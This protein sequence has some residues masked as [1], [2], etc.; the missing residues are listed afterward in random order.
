VIR[1]LFCVIAFALLLPASS[2]AQETTPEPAPQQSG[3]TIHVV[4]RGET[5]FRI[6][7]RYG[8][9]VDEL[10]RLNGISDPGSI[11]VGQRLLVPSTG[12]PEPVEAVT[13]I[14]QP[15]ETLRSI[16]ESYGTTVETLVALNNIA[17][18]NTIY[19]GQVLTITPA[20][21]AAAPTS[22]PVSVEAAP[23]TAMVYVVQ[24]GETLFRIA[25]RF[26]LTVNDL[27]T[28]NSIS[29]P[30]V[31]YVGQQLI[32]P[33]FEPP[34]LALDLPEPVTALDVR[35]L[36][37]VEGQAAWIRLTT[38]E[39]VTMGGTFFQ[40]VLNIISEQNNTQ[41]NILIGVPLGTAAGVYA[42]DLTVTH[43]AGIQIP[44]TINLQI[45]SG[46]YGVEN[47]TLLADR[48]NLL[49][50]A[51]EQ[52]E[53]DI[54]TSVMSIYTL[55]RYFDGPMG[56]PAAAA[57][58][59][60][61]GA[62]RSYNGGET[63]RRHTGTDFAGAPG[64]PVLAAASGVV[65]LADTLNVRGNAVVIDHGWGVFTGYWH[66]AEL[67]VAVG[68]TV[69]TGQVIGTIG[70]TGRVTGAHLHWEVWVSGVPVDPMQW[71]QQSFP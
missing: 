57:V 39:A 36:I 18:A 71:I 28:A 5:L 2:Y 44:L 12:V 33:G 25:T 20:A 15:G 7:L 67:F 51:V 23:V 45:L 19:V 40:R 3:V 69:T 55:E 10:V 61:F 42:L 16:A 26:G 6:A 41:H 24:P 37:L 29:D 52:A 31:I 59:S 43:S 49:E 48:G 53:L 17:N 63:S 22:E 35:P 60:A 54:I 27:V 11:D 9:T 47:I 66:Q 70:S 64:T 50:P 34:H 21:A 58:T 68:E 62:T 32:I 13:H 65:V 1:R 56:L 46:G 30:S 8:T 14:V 4:Q 38:S